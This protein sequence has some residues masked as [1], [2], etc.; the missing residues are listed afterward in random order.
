MLI[1]HADNHFNSSYSQSL[2]LTDD[3]SAEE[4]SMR[5]ISTAPGSLDPK[6]QD[7]AEDLKDTYFDVCKD[8]PG[9]SCFHHRPLNCHF[10]LDR[11]KLLVWAKDIVSSDFN[12]YVL[13]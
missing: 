12:H 3:D 7:I 9:Q 6:L 5:K 13:V 2:S 1:Y 4:S 8:H 11:V 10:V